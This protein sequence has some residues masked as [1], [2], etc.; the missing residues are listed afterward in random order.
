[1]HVRGNIVSDFIQNLTITGGNI[2]SESLKKE[3]A[4][5]QFQYIYKRIEKISFPPNTFFEF[6][7]ED[8]EI[9]KELINNDIVLTI[10][11]AESA[12]VA[13]EIALVPEL[14]TP[15]LNLKY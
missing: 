2:V 15:F 1:M 8:T 3:F 6:S 9:V 7:T 12:N 13:N 10:D 14:N 5:A 11:S 4:Y